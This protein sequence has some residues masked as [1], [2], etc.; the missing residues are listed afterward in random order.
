MKLF[1]TPNSP[2]ARIAR[3]A[4]LDSGLDRDLDCREAKL[5]VPD[6]PVLAHCPL[7]RVPTLVDGDLVLGQARAICAYFDAVCGVR[8][9]FPDEDWRARSLE[10]L[11]TGFLDGIAVWVRELRRPEGGQSAFLL[12]VERARAERCLERLERE[13]VTG[14]LGAGWDFAHIQLACALGIMAHSLARFDWSSGRP[15]LAAWFASQAAR[16]SMAATRPI[17]V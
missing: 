17:P 7:G 10:G 2:Y 14:G 9:F 16:P 4:A 8:R 15:V 13:L 11:V 1:Y 3:I 6:N 5:R 12:E